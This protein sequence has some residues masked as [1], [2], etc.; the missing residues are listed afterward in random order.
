MDKKKIV[1]WALYDWANSAFSTTVMAGFFPVFFSKYW[2][3]GADANLTTTRLGTAISISSLL[4]AIVSPTLGAMADLRGSKKTYNFIFMCLGSLCCILLGIIGKGEWPIAILVY[5][6]AMMAFNASGVFYDSLLPEVAEGRDM[7]YASS[8]GYSL[9]YLGG[10]L[11][12]SF[13]VLM[14]QRPQM[15]G[16]AD[17]AAA[18]KISFI[19]VGI[20]WFIFTLPLQLNV[21]EKV[22]TSTLSKE[23]LNY[24]IFQKS[25]ASLRQLLKTFRELMKNRNLF[26]YLIAYWFFIDG[27]YTVMTMAVD[28]G[29]NIG[30]ESKDLI[31]ALLLTQFIGFPFAWLFGKVTGRLGCRKPILFCIVIYALIVLMASRMS[32][33]SEFYLLAAV[34]GMVQG[35]VQSLSRSMFG[36]MIPASSSAEYFG[37]FNLV[38]RFASILGPLFI[39]IGTYLTGNVRIGLLS[40][41][42]LFG[43][44]GYLLFQVQEKE[45]LK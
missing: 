39:G 9:G 12:F 16:L 40:L 1:S 17:G 22:P 13:N 35:G 14:F 34:I 24:S 26:I 7:D 43:V 29:I 3:D 6:F 11:L 15:F 30:L 31:T 42:I 5:G 4:M 27:V 28:F 21:K 19:S 32:S 38:G 41:L 37:F 2:S 20:W 45:I 10:G 25:Q 23:F 33:S 44:G 36:Q 8:L 18:V